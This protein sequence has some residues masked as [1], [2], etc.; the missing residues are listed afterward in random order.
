MENDT[1]V[2]VADQAGARIFACGRLGRPLT[3]V[4]E[5]SH[6][7]GSAHVGELLADGTAPRVQDAQS[8]ARHSMAERS[9]VKRELSERFARQLVNTLEKARKAG[10]FAKLALVAPPQLLGQLREQLHRPLADTVVLELDK[11]LTDA[12]PE[13]LASALDEARAAAQ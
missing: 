12:S 3:L 9:D 1:W 5:I 10:R 4:E 6:A 8:G 2:L 13:A 7:E 11:H